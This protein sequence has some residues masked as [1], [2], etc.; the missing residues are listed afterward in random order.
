M[1]LLCILSGDDK[2]CLNVVSIQAHLIYFGQVK[3]RAPS[4]TP[5]NVELNQKRIAGKNSLNR[6]RK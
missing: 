6:T 4:E 1:T 3:V 2:L 5:A